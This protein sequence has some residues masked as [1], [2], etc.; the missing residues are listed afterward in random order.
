MPTPLKL[1]DPPFADAPLPDNAHFAQSWD[2]FFRDVADQLAK[3]ADEL[4]SNAAWAALAA[5]P[6]YADDA[7]AAAGGVPVGYRYRNGS[8]VMVRVS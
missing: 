1:V 8:A 3:L 6:S 4:E 7:A 5:S 2:R